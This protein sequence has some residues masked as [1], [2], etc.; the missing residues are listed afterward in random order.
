MVKL[1]FSL[2]LGNRPLC[3]AQTIK[4]SEFDFEELIEKAESA[5]VGG[6]KF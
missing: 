6:I 4:V 5:V 3:N 2:G 1:V